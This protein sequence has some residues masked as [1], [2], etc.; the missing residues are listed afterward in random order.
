VKKY[1]HILF[2]ST[3]IADETDAL[4]QALSIARNNEAD[5][6]VLIIYPEFPHHFSEYEEKHVQSL[7]ND[8]HASIVKVS[9]QIG[10]DIK[11]LNLRIEAKRKGKPSVSIIQHVLKNSVDLLIKQA[12]QKESGKGFK[13]LDMDLL[14]R[15]PCPVW[16]CRAIEHHRKDIKIAVAIDAESEGEEVRD[17]SIKLLKSA[18]I[19]AKNCKNDIHVISCW[20][21]LFEEYLRYKSWT[22]TPEN[23]VNHTITEAKDRHLAALNDVIKDAHISCNLT[24]HNIRGAADD[25]IPQFIDEH[26]VDILIMGTIGRS[27]LLGFI[28]G[29]TAENIFQQLSCS[30]LALK[31]NGFV[32]PIKAY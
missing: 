31:P 2:V 27:G 18:D 9:E 13:A 26:G 23:E 10:V 19:M 4:K 3:G 1:Q 11:A 8:L 6:S 29:N 14:R 22:K 12:E 20:D 5:F 25:L 7:M 17:L 30:L 16:L 15:C 21:Y 24:I 28:I 32:S